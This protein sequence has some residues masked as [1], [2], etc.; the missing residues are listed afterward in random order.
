MQRL[1]DLELENQ[2]LMEDRRL[3]NWLRARD[4][5]L[6]AAETMFRKHL[7]WRQEN[8]IDTILEPGFNNIPEEALKMLPADI[9]G[10]DK[11]GNPVTVLF[12]GG[13]EI[14]KNIQKYGKKTALDVFHFYLEAALEDL[15]VKSTDPY[16]FRKADYILDIEDLRFK[17]CFASED[18]FAT[19]L[20]EVEANY[21]EA[22]NKAYVLNAPSVLPVLW[23]ILKPFLSQKTIGNVHFFNSN[24]AQF[25]SALLEQIDISQLPRKWGGTGYSQRIH[26]LNRFIST[27]EISAE[28]EENCRERAIAA[29]DTFELTFEVEAPNA[30]LS[31]ITYDI[32]S[33]KTKSYDIGF[34]VLHR[35][36]SGSDLEEK[37]IIEYKRVNVQKLVHSGSLLCEMSGHYILRFDNTYSR[38]RAKDIIYHVEMTEPTINGSC[39]ADARNKTVSRLFALF[40]T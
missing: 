31:I 23:N 40:S 1:R 26:Q 33:F 29:G 35:P 37:E 32:W 21:P 7:D 34:A 2:D 28:F 27:S 18:T 24:L 10:V 16:V 19:F 8:K 14:K 20:K 13:F 38:L 30:L 5:K 9:V 22:L 17:D 3:I 25:Q 12:A 4:L 39:I 36:F 15:R 11:Y 6:D